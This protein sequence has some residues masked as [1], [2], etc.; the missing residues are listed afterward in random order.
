MRIETGVIA[1]R[2]GQLPEGQTLSCPLTKK[3]P[4]RYAIKLP[5]L[6]A[7][8][9]LAITGY[10]STA[11]VMHPAKPEAASRPAAAARSYTSQLYAW[12]NPR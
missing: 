2:E 7:T 1:A 5:W 12:A 4:M 8:G 10:G 3:L 9:A 11:A 6:A